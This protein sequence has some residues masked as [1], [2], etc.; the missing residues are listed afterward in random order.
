M[1]LVTVVGEPGLGKS[2][3]VAELF[4]YIDGRPEF[5]TWRQGRC[6][7][8]GEGITFWALGE[9]LKAHTGILESDP[10]R[11]AEEKLDAVLPEGEERAWFRQRLL[12]LLGIEATSRGGAGGVVHGLAAVPGGGRGGAADGAG[13]RGSALGRRG[14]ARVPGAPGRPR[15]R[16]PAADRLH[17]PAGAVRAVSRLRGRAAERQHDQP[18]AAVAGGDGP[19][20]LGAARCDGA[21]G[22]VAAA[23]PRTGRW[24]PACTR[25][26]SCA[27]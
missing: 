17:G 24:Q 10:P 19:S 27:S 8:Y 14:D 23:D 22:R 16:R 1:Q 5:T 25:R 21:A 4:A 26:S 13:V 3:L 15:R 18:G 6:L 11:V 2:R 7:P 12:P 9:I 20:H